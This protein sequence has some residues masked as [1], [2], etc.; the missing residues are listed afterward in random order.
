MLSLPDSMTLALESG[1][2]SAICTGRLYPQEYPS[3]HFSR[4][5]VDPGHME[6]SDAT[7]KNP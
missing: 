7:E 2:L 5:C 1:R 6:L 4:G 3:N